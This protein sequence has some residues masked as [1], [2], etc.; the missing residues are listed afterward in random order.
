MVLTI[1]TDCDQ[2]TITSTLL[3]NFIAAPSSYTKVEVIGK[4]QCGTAIVKEYTSSSPIGATGDVITS[5]GTEYINPSFFSADDFSDG[6]YSITVKLYPLSGSPTSDAG[7]LFVDCNTLCNICIDDLWSLLYH[8]T[9][10]NTQDCGCDCQKLC[11]MFSL[12]KLASGE[13]TSST[14]SNCGC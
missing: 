1:N 7:C 5:G 13:S 4:Y 9:I 14:T 2:I 11:D 10:T 12:I 3:N 8:Y 6:I